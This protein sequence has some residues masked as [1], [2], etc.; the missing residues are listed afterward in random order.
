MDKNI[1]IKWLT[2][3][4]YHYLYGGGN[5]IK[6]CILNYQSWKEYKT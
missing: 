6:K 1:M 5:T 4:C 3:F 2:W